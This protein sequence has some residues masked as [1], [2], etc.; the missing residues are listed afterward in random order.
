MSYAAERRLL[1]IVVALIGAVPVI[2]GFYGL[3][4]G[5][6]IFGD[7]D[8]RYRYLS[9]LEL[10][11]GAAFWASI[12]RIEDRGELFRVLTLIVVVGGLARLGA[13]FAVPPSNPVIYALVLELV[14]TPLA[15]LW[16]ERI[17][18]MDAAARP[19]YRGPWE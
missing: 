1:Q 13:A 18:R 12:A 2:A 4:G 8:S 14:I 16:R 11:L 6:G 5:L 7:A 3:V 9:G 15:C 17:E 19:G 10:G